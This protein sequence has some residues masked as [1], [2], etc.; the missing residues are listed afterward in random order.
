MCLFIP[1]KVYSHVI[2]SVHTEEGEAQ[3]R[4]GMDWCYASAITVIVALN[5]RAAVN[6]KEAQVVDL[7]R[8]YFDGRT[9]EKKYKIEGKI[10]HSEVRDLKK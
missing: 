7:L 5:T 2:S 1:Y 8:H 10:K 6:T 9:G 3:G 4:E